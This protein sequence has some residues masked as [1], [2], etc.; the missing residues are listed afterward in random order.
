MALPDRNLA[1]E[2]V[3][4]TEAAAMAASRW[5][6]RGDKNGADGA[7]VDAMRTIL[8]TVPMDGIVVIGEGEKDEAPMLYNGERVGDGSAPEVDI[9]VDP[10]EGTTLTAL[11][12]GNAISVIAMSERGTMFDPGPCVYM[13][14]IAVGPEAAGVVDITR[15]PTQNLTAVAQAKGES[16]RDVTAV[17]LD[18]PRHEELI[19]EVRTAGA[20]IRL[21][22]DGDVIGAVST[23]L[24]D[25]GADI[26]L[27]IGG[28]P[29]GVIAAAAM[30]CMGG[31]I[32]GRLWPRNDDERA[33][34]I[35]AGYD[36]DRVLRTDDLVSGD[37]AFFSL[38]GITDGEVLKGV[39]YDAR[40]ATTQ[41]L[42]MR[43]RSGTVRI[44]SARHRL[45]KLRGFSAINFE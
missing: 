7:A 31:E 19:A 45:Q 5:M 23:A 35:A 34:A 27:G 20:R 15:T 13:E 42:V 32:Q 43:S 30:K 1:L 10:V 8:D 14:K 40:G 39:H 25:T 33:A 2:L 37:N 4:V 17:I 21:I 29:E 24:P 38:T 18:R 11:G 28:T 12:R 26:L 9:A 6:G 3:R 36:L 16:I 22:Q 44:V 41:S